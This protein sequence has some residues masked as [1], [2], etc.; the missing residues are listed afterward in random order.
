MVLAVAVHDG[1]F[2]RSFGSQGSGDG[3][4]NGP[5]GLAVHGDCVYVAEY[6]NHRVSV[7][8][9]GDGK[10]VRTIGSGRI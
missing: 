9:R 7:F 8:A 2:V 3:Q 4:L 5:Y 1:S 6:T 10:F